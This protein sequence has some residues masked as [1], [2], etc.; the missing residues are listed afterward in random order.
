M[1]IPDNRVSTCR[2]EV[3]DWVQNS[4]RQVDF[5]QSFKILNVICTDFTWILM[6]FCNVVYY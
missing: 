4:S 3:L 5:T 1:F 2:Y 6:A